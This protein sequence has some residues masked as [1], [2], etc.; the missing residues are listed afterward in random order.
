MDT[1]KFDPEIFE[2]IKETEGVEIISEK[3]LGSLDKKFFEQYLL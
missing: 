3:L 1:T 2:Y